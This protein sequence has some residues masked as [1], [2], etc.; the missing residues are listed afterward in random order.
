M[1][2][3]LNGGAPAHP[4]VSGRERATEGSVAA[5]A[6][7]VDPSPYRR[8]TRAAPRHR[9]ADA[10]GVARLLGRHAE[11]V[12]RAGNAP[13]PAFI[14]CGFPR[15]CPLRGGRK[16]RKRREGMAVRY[17]MSRS[18]LF[19]PIPLPWRGLLTLLA[20]SALASSR[21]WVPEFIRW[22]FA[23]FR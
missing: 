21:W 9:H 22:V 2:T 4:A 3:A 18:P 1:P 23:S 7:R 12:V 17:S 10:H 19:E 8:H 16:I 5:V 14:P 13:R 6:A 11:P 20:L 15:S